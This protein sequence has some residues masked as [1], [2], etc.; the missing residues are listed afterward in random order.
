ML[1]LFRKKGNEEG[2]IKAPSYDPYNRYQ[3]T[4]SGVF[5]FRKDKHVVVPGVTY[6]EQKPLELIKDYVENETGLPCTLSQELINDMYSMYVNTQVKKRPESSSNTVRH[7]VLD[8]IYDSLTKIVTVNSPLYTQ[9]L[10]RE[11]AL[12]LQKV[13]EQV[14][15]EQEK[16]GEPNPNGLES[17]SE[18]KEDSQNQEGEGDGEG[19]SNSNSSGSNPDQGGS[20]AGK[21]DSSGSRSSIENIVKKALDKAEDKI[22]EAKEKADEKIKELENQL[23]KEAMKDLMNNDPEFLE[24]VDELK[25][26]LRAVSINKDSIK[27]VLVKILNES[28]NYFSAKYKRVEESL[29]DCEECEDLFGL[30]FLHPIFKNAEIMSVGNESRVYKGKIDLYLDC[31]GSMSSSQNFEGKYIPMSDLA[32]GIAMIL[33]RMGMI[34]NLYFFDCS[35]YKIDNVNEITILSFSKS[36]GTDFDNVVNMINANGNNA[37]V[38]TDGQDRCTKYTKKAFWIGV[39]G[40]KFE[41]DYGDSLFSDYRNNS[42]CVTYNSNTSN[43][44]YCKK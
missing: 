39:G 30:E 5:G 36:G 17:S 19:K 6:Y 15:N 1:D 16:N 40:T 32:K 8:K 22:E 14:K 31:S 43:F 11:F 37:V 34:D 9:I 10:T 27:K 41:N 3:N 24:K 2:V 33:Y 12:V 18:N 44:D 7:M 28:L 38:I 29:F 21:G 4:G 20:Q 35:L 23:G 13:D 26:R 25:D 42:Q